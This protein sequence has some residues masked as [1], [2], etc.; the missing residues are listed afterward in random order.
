MKITGHK[1]T[2]AL[3]HF[4]LSEQVPKWMLN[5]SP[6]QHAALQKVMQQHTLR[7]S[8]ETPEERAARQKEDSV[9]HLVS[10]QHLSQREKSHLEDLLGEASMSM[11][12][13][14]YTGVGKALNMFV[15]NESYIFDEVECIG[16]GLTIL[17]TI[18]G[19]KGYISI[20]PTSS[21]DFSVQVQDLDREPVGKK[22]IMPS[23]TA[24]RKLFDIAEKLAEEML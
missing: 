19:N 1:L 10:K 12:R 18:T 15:N 17:F 2:E 21:S 22:I 5:M 24:P 8:S 6:E 13:D 16:N 14:T 9:T 11:L 4:M 3:R 23:T 7:R 20:T